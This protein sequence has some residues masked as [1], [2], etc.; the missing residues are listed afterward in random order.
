MHHPRSVNYV[1]MEGHKVPDQVV[2]S[3]LAYFGLAC[4]ILI[5]GFVLV[6]IDN[7][8]FTTSATSVVSCFMNIGPGLNLTGPAGNFALFS[9]FSKIV[10]SVMMLLGRLEIF[11]IQIGRAHV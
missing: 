3:T 8:D 9:H 2:K 1:R 5:A 7:K 10:L 6:S 4:L 11:P